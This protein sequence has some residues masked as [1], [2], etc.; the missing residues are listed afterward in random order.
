MQSSV[1]VAAQGDSMAFT[2]ACSLVRSCGNTELTADKHE[3]FDGD[4]SA[5]DA[6]ARMLVGARCLELCRR[7]DW[8]RTAAIG[9]SIEAALE[10][11]SP[12]S[13][14]LRNNHWTFFVVEYV[15]FLSEVHT[16]VRCVL[17]ARGP[18]LSL[19]LVTCTTLAAL[20][21]CSSSVY[22]PAYPKLP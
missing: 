10:E 8:D 19:F 21:V 12:E 11:G 15:H 1:D 18:S 14:A 5:K 4:V 22:T 2:L 3:P 17:Y 20:C 9:R 13:G 16:Q 6:W 7:S